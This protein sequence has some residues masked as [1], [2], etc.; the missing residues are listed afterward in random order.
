MTPT[1]PGCDGEHS[2]TRKRDSNGVN[3][4]AVAAADGRTDESATST[5]SVLITQITAITN[6]LF[7]D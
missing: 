2:T 7:I 1:L 5:G 3:V 6:P 4:V